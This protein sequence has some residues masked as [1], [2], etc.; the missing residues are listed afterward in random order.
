MMAP[1]KRSLWIAAVLL[2]LLAVLLYRHFGLGDLLTLDS[3]KASRDTLTALYADRPLFTV[4]AF[5]GLYV[6]AT[7]LS[8]PGATILTLAAGAMFGLGVGLVVVSFASSLGALLAFLVARYLL[9]DA[10]QSRF[11]KQLGPIN[12]GMARDGIFYLLSAANGWRY[13]W[14]GCGGYR[15]PPRLRAVS[16]THRSCRFREG[17]LRC[18]RRIPPER[19]GS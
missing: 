15:R 13:R 3:L 1:S 11:G 8:F 10:V 12:E 18:C 9:R 6:V 19:A 5:F 14:C 7:A 4:T 2:A 17:I 16:A